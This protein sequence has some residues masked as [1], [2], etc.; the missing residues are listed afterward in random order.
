MQQFIFE[1]PLWL[2]VGGLFVAVVAGVLWTQSGARSAWLTGLVAVALTAVLVLVSIRV[3]TDR[4][5]VKRTIQEVADAVEAN[6]L[7]RVMSYIH[8]NAAAGVARAQQELPQ[9]RFR[10]AHMSQLK[11]IVVNPNST[12]PTAVA[13]FHVIVDL[14]AEGQH[15]RFPRFVKAYFVKDNARWLVRDYEHFDFGVGLRDH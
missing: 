11:S 13:E 9:Y 6:D 10:E 14:E 3:E 2:G 15:A 5:Q 7:K 8:P 1:N 12:P 4:E